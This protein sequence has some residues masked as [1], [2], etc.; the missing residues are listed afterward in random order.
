ME[1]TLT[2]IIFVVG[3]GYAIELWNHQWKGALHKEPLKLG[4][5]GKEVLE[6]LGLSP[7][8]GEQ[9]FASRRGVVLSE[10]ALVSS[11]PYGVITGL[12][13]HGRYQIHQNA[14]LRLVSEDLLVASKVCFILSVWGL[15]FGLLFGQPDLTYYG[16]TGS[17]I[18][19]VLGL[20]SIFVN[21]SYSQQSFNQ[22]IKAKNIDGEDQKTI[23]FYLTLDFL[24][25]ISKLLTSPIKWKLN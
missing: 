9:N 18:G 17:N 20:V 25:E 6:T 19:I 13:S 1:G 7:E 16:N 8:P 3:V 22:L 12:I 24:Q 10:Q 14:L 21:M 11:A 2:S 15:I 4:L 23:R 5:T